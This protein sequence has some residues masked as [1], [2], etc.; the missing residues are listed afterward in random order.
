MNNDDFEGEAEDALARYLAWLRGEG[1][2]PI[3]APPAAADAAA[4][5]AE[6]PGPMGPLV[7]F[8]PF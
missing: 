5:A 4:A 7:S 6:R 2:P 3:P 1:P 8:L